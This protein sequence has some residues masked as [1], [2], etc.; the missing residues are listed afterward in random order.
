LFTHQEDHD[1]GKLP[2]VI[3]DDCLPGSSD[4]AV[5]L[6]FVRVDAELIAA[7]IDQ[8]P[9]G[10]LPFKVMTPVIELLP[11]GASTLRGAKP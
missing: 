5:T 11:Q 2:V 9:H 10:A 3:D 7:H 4:V 8:R 1:V 6:T